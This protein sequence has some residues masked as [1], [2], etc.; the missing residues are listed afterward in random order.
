MEL[1]E[2]HLRY[3]LAIGE[4]QGTTTRGIGTV[5]LAKYLPCSSASV[6]NM[7]NNLM[8]MG[9]LARK[10]YGKIYLTDEGSRL[11]AELSACMTVILQQLT[12]LELDLPI[13]ELKGMSV[14]LLSRLSADN[15]TRLAS[16]V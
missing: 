12:A 3:L 1:R 14:S 6:T 7:V 11:N 4:L 8:E 15:R 13:E 16:C 9:L 2:A 5:E 10:R